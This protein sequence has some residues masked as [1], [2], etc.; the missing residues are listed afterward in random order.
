M[1]SLVLKAVLAASLLAVTACSSAAAEGGSATG[2]PVRGGEL[3]YLDAEIPISAL[4]QEQGTWQDRALF[5]NITDRLL[6]RNAETG[7]LEPWIA[8][9]WKV[10]ADGLRYDFVIRDGVTYSD[11]SPLDVASVQ[12]NLTRQIFGDQQKALAK[13]FAFPAEGEITTEPASRT[14]TVQLKKPW[15][16]FLGALTGWAA[17]LVD[18]SVFGLTR[19]QQSEYRNLVGSGPFVVESVEYG[20]SYVLKRRPGYA[21]APKSSPNQGEAYLDKITVIP[22]QEDSVRLG[23]LRSG[24]ADLLRYVQPSEEKSLGA[25]GFTVVARSGVGLTNQWPLRQNVWPGDD[26]NVRKALQIGIDRDRIIKDLY[27]G[28]WS[29]ATGV[30][31]PGTLGYTDASAQLAYDKD[32]AGQLLDQSGFTARDAEGYRTKDGRR[33]KLRTYVDVYDSTAKALFQHAQAQVKELGIELEIDETDYGSYSRTVTA[34]PLVNFTRSGWP[35]PDPAH[36][37]WNNYASGRA[38]QLKLKGA[39]AKLEQLLDR[40][41]HATSVEAEQAALAE[42]QK[43]LLDNALTIPILNDTQVYVGAKDLQ[44]FSLSDGGLPN[45]QRAWLNR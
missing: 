16:P 37:L 35:H 9:S 23:T 18:D 15:A 38:D 29:A 6:H 44:G 17:G 41:L 34:D 40:S 30:L 31:S 20:K 22:V 43:Y 14:V 21:W 42:T 10:S 28:N 12:R 39:D 19:E 36:G 8:E 3:T 27:T 24:Q 25:Q 1:R 5:W 32:K 26:V 33:L 2:E 13:N 4:I 11:G 45:Y 7:E